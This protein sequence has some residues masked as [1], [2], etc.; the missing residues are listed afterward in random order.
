QMLFLEADEVCDR[1][2]KDRNG[3]YMGQLGVTLPRS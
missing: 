2:Y 3:K 1:S